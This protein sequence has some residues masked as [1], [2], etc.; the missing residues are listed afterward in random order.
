MRD[1]TSQ[2]FWEQQAEAVDMLLQVRLAVETLTDLRVSAA[3][4]QRY[5]PL[6]FAAV[7][8]PDVA[9]NSA[10][11]APRSLIDTSVIDVLA[12]FGDLVAATSLESDLSV[13]ALERSRAALDEVSDLL[14]RR[15]IQLSRAAKEYS[16][17]LISRVRQLLDGN[18]ALGGIDLRR[19]INELYGFLTQLA[20]SLEDDPGK[21][22]LGKMVRKAARDILPWAMRGITAAGVV[23]EGIENLREITGR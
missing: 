16:F 3:H 9:W 11:S 12:S 18:A 5:L 8:N 23:L 1:S 20:D 14:G 21:V 15:D 4:Y 13:T 10:Q 6:W 17:E 22:E 7:F 2:G 19:N